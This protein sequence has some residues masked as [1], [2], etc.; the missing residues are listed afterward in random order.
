MDDIINK[1]NENAID[2]LITELSN[3]HPAGL[4][5]SKQAREISPEIK[6]IWI[7]VEG[8]HEFQEQIDKIG[9]IKCI[10]KPLDIKRFKKHV[11]EILE[12]D[13]D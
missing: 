12:M 10:E 6:I 2:L 11:L 9:N 4:I 13:I 5:I 1:I 8:C 3:A 7:T